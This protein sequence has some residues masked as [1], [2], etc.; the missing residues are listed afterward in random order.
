MQKI[1]SRQQNVES[2]TYKLKD[3]IQKQKN[4]KQKIEYRQQKVENRKQNI[5]NKNQ[6]VAS[7]TKKIKTNNEQLLDDL[8]EIFQLTAHFQK[9]RTNDRYQKHDQTYM[10]FLSWFLKTN[11]FDKAL[12]SNN[13][14]DC[15]FT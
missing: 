5:K 4:R 11:Q 3:R 13:T 6:K 8:T 15:C 12:K 14:N 7:R 1:E 10:I 2:R 9:F